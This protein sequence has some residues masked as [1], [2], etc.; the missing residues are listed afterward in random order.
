MLNYSN[1][2]IPQ[3]KLFLLNKKIDLETFYTILTY[4]LY[5]EKKTIKTKD[6]GKGSGSWRNGKPLF[7]FVWK[8]DKEYSEFNKS[9]ALY[10]NKENLN[11]VL[12]NKLV[13]DTKY[14]KE[15]AKASG[16]KNFQFF[17]ND[18]GI[19][20]E[21]LK[22]V[23]KNQELMEA[24]KEGYSAFNDF[25]N[26]ILELQEILKEKS[27]YV[28]NETINQYQSKIDIKDIE[29]NYK[30]YSQ[31]KDSI[32]NI[33][34][35]NVDLG[36]INREKIKEYKELLD[37]DI[38]N[39]IDENTYNKILLEF[40]IYKK[41]FMD[42][43]YGNLTFLKN[44]RDS[45]IFVDFINFGLSYG[46]K[47][48]AIAIN[49]YLK[50][51]G[52]KQSA[53]A[54]Y[55]AGKEYELFIRQK[56]EFLK[57]TSWEGVKSVLI[58][59][60][61]Y[62]EDEAKETY[63]KLYKKFNDDWK[64]E[65]NKDKQ[66]SNIPQCIAGDLS[67]KKD[68]LDE[69]T[70]SGYNRKREKVIISTMDNVNIVKKPNQ[71]KLDKLTVETADAET[72]SQLVNKN[73]QSSNYYYEDRGVDLLKE[74]LQNYTDGNIPFEDFNYDGLV[75]EVLKAGAIIDNV[76]YRG[77]KSNEYANSIINLSIGE[78]FNIDIG[79]AAVEY[80][81]IAATS[82]VLLRINGNKNALFISQ[83]SRFCEESEVLI[84]GT[85]KKTKQTINP[86]NGY[87]I[88][89]I[90]QVFPSKR[91]KAKDSIDIEDFEI[92]LSYIKWLYF[93]ELID[94]KTLLWLLRL[95]NS[96][97]WFTKKTMDSL[98]FDSFENHKGRIGKVGG[99]L[100]R[101]V[102]TSKLA[103]DFK[104]YNYKD[105]IGY[106]LLKSDDLMDSIQKYLNDDES[107]LSPN[108]YRE[109]VEKSL[110]KDLLD[111][112]GLYF[113]DN[114]YFKDISRLEQ[115]EFEADI[116]TSLA[117]E[118]ASDT[119]E[120]LETFTALLDLKINT[121]LKHIYKYLNE[122]TTIDKKN[123]KEETRIL[124][125]I[126]EAGKYYEDALREKSICFNWL[127]DKDL[128][129]Q[130]ENHIE[131]RDLQL[132]L[133]K[134]DDIKEFFD[135]NKY[136]SI[137]IE[138]IIKKEPKAKYKAINKLFMSRHSK[139]YDKMCLSLVDNSRV[140]IKEDYDIDKNVDMAME[141]IEKLNLNIE[142]NKED[143]R[144]LFNPNALP[145][146]YLGDASYSYDYMSENDMSFADMLR[147]YTIYYE[148]RPNEE[149]N[150]VLQVLYKYAPTVTS[151]VYRVQE[152]GF[153]KNKQI[154]FD[155][156]RS[157][158]SL[159][160]RFEISTYGEEKYI[161]Q[162][163]KK[164]LFLQAFSYFPSQAELILGGSYEV[165]SKFEDD[166]EYTNYIVKPIDN[167]KIKDSFNRKIKDGINT[168]KKNEIIY[169]IDSLIS[170]NKKL[171]NYKRPELMNKDFKLN[172]KIT[173]DLRDSLLKLKENIKKLE[174]IDYNTNK[175]RY[176][177]NKEFDENRGI[178]NLF[179][180]KITNIDNV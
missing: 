178:S 59:K 92:K 177:I 109:I 48:M 128:R 14:I 70:I 83:F 55:Q 120:R 140:Q 26:K 51:E 144:N 137:D 73:I 157:C 75:K 85:F 7:N 86:F 62:D 145:S 88:I 170:I 133:P 127:M 79:S 84:G 168:L 110:L 121:G 156:F 151:D 5:F 118:D 72:I 3:L 173:S 161:I 43:E 123:K 12:V 112:N 136:Y 34:F 20:L 27:D 160:K 17:L 81:G 96:G 8:D 50:N 146:S 154:N 175:L 163:D 63:D 58:S 174:T 52:N 108:S 152:R 76:C 113:F 30:E 60:K 148:N 149:A 57:M 54:L 116:F 130:A 147:Y 64:E 179:S 176:R 9:M 42:E 138:S 171:K 66:L 39:T 93:T 129:L 71:K 74:A 13:E 15:I 28:D 53:L 24:Y 89:D 126:L 31:F 124:S 65:L 119:K 95:I 10:E 6:G 94:L 2:N 82:P 40:E 125:K 165:V 172:S 23:L 1:Y 150:K 21:D 102:N 135:K 37:S 16:Q 114:L 103:E 67:V 41:S 106:D 25:Y 33:E 99:S 153:L 166:N 100:P 56:D 44:F 167:K 80:T 142:V 78:E 104:D 105:I 45:Q 131:Y 69:L 11:P 61:D 68:I 134:E 38:V 97:I 18:L 132:E 122:L 101:G 36:E 111:D 115:F 29:A 77:V 22:D 46:K 98:L 91:K 117:C 155:T 169:I 90:E 139:L 162:G 87:T 141:E 180:K 32:K 4:K 159:E 158:S 19:E 143:I 49:N 47:N 107:I 35:K 164:A